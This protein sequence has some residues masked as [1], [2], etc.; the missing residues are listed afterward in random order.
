MTESN[1][2]EAN[3]EL[4]NAGSSGHPLRILQ[5]KADKFARL[6]FNLP[7]KMLAH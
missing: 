5:E 3:D 4:T 1:D 6:S 7:L 2:W